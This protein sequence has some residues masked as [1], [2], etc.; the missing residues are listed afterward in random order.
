MYE[1]RG[2]RVISAAC[3]LF[4][5]MPST[6]SA[7]V[8]DCPAFFSETRSTKYQERPGTTTYK[9]LKQIGTSTRICLSRICFVS[10]S[11]A[12]RS[13]Q[14][15]L[16]EARATHSIVPPHGHACTLY[17]LYVHPPPRHFLQVPF[18]ANP[19]ILVYK[20]LSPLE[21]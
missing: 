12:S 16:S 9:L 13:I 8:F 7:D 14:C 10:E 17:G 11:P 2:R 4:Q 18:C 6:C 20:R 21:S 5:Q 1:S 19:S 15:T 3:S